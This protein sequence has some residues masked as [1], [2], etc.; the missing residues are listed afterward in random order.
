MTVS[1]FSTGLTGCATTTRG[2]Q[3][4]AETI[5]S[6]VAK[7]KKGV[8]TYNEVVEKLGPPQYAFISDGMLTT[9]YNVYEQKYDSSVPIIGSFVSSMIGIGGIASIATQAAT[10]SA[11]KDTNSQTTTI[12]IFN[13]KTKILQD[14]L[15]TASSGSTRR[16]LAN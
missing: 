5:Q 13:Q 6:E 15:Q 11:S 12:L 16:N 3:K 14:V 2:S 8:T 7:F 4:S 9:H 10:Q 1:V